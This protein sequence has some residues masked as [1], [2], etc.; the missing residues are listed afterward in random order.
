M[1]QIDYVLVIYIH[2]V[3]PYIFLLVELQKH[4]VKLAGF[5][6]LDAPLVN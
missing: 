5:H 2:T 3:V 4:C 1:L 6:W